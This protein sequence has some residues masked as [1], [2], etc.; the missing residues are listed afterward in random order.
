MAE[1][2]SRNERAAIEPRAEDQDLWVF[3]YGS[4]MWRPGFDYIERQPALLHG[5]HRALCILSYDHRGTREIPGL[6]LGLDRGGAC[7]GVAFRVAAKNRAE[8]H[9]YLVAREQTSMVYEER[10]HP[11]KLG[12]GRRVIGLAYTANRNH[13]QYSGVMT[14]EEQLAHVRRGVGRSG[15]NPD[16]VL[17]T[18]AHLV[19][20]GVHDALLDWLAKELR[21]N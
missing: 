2:V 8:T 20:I 4:L 3:G 21:A 19:E 16:Y 10:M 13:E 5:Y 9:A 6:V 15:A 7:R 12:D 17:N 1:V 18:H 14:R 11:L